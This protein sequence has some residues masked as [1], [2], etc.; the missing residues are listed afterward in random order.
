VEALYWWVVPS[1]MLPCWWINGRFD[2]NRNHWSL[3]PTVF[4]GRCL[5][6]GVYDELMGIL[7]HGCIGK[8]LDSRLLDFHDNVHR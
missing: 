7:V 3:F 6:V 1:P 4:E 8:S 5:P 2:S